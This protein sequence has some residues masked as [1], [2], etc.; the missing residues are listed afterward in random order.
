MAF[1]VAMSP[2]AVPRG[3]SGAAKYLAGVETQISQTNNT[4]NGARAG[5]TA[6]LL[7][8]QNRRLL[9]LESQTN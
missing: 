2:L 4:A 3:R 1:A 8:G 6:R 9:A 7:H 5:W